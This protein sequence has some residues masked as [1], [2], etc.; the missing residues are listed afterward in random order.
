MENQN[1]PEQENQA[2]ILAET[3]KLIESTI[4]ELK[5]TTVTDEAIAHLKA[6]Y[7]ALVVAGIEDM[8]GYKAVKAGVTKLRT[9]RTSIESRR[10][11]LTEPALKFQREVKAEADRIV[12]ELKP[13]EERLKEE[14]QRIDDAKEAKRREQYQLRIQQLTDNGYQLIN[15]FFVCGPIQIHSDEITNISDAQMAIHIKHGQDE[16]VRR[17]AERQRQADEA[18]R[19]AAERAEIERMK[20]ELE[21]E[22]AK[23]A[24]ERAEITAQKQALQQTYDVVVEPERPAPSIEFDMPTHADAP[25]IQNVESLLNASVQ[26][27]PEPQP[28]PSEFPVWKPSNEFERGF[29]AFRVE[30]DQLIKNTNIQLSR[31]SLHQWTWNIPFP[32]H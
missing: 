23:A 16:L 4:V 30:L 21:A 10:K 5:R 20:A 7:G 28:Q 14:V 19:I 32:K 3:D 9:L 1:T 24:Q 27:E 18:E 6:E 25:P 2:L 31:K 26:P 13:L 17:E 22:K 12:S 29:N 8:Q 11:E 15:G